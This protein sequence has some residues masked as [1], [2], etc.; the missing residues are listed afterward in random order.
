[1]KKGGNVGRIEKTG[2]IEHAGCSFHE[3]H[4]AGTAR[5]TLRF[6]EN[7]GPTNRFVFSCNPAVSILQTQGFC[8]SATPMVINSAPDLRDSPAKGPLVT[9]SP[10]EKDVQASL[11]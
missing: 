7:Y 1:M 10:S 4:I 9:A 6:P 2:G 11:S 5:K 8:G 3:D